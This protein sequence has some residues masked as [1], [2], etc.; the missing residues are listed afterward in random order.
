[1]SEKL[2][3]LQRRCSSCNTLQDYG[4][5]G[6]QKNSPDGLKYICKPCEAIKAQRYRE[7]NRST[8]LESQ[9]SYR[10][11][12]LDAKRARHK[13]WSEKNKSKLAALSATRRTK[14]PEKARAYVRSWMRE[15]PE[16]AAMYAMR[17][18]TGRTI[19]TPAW[20]NQSKIR[21]IYQ[22]SIALSSLHGVPFHVDHIVPLQGET[23]CGLHVENNLE[24]LASTDNI[25]K[26]NK[27]WPGMADG[28]A[29]V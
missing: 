19:A 8:Y 17:Y 27:V 5:F 20:A 15:N 4:V 2:E 14:D 6:K 25:K 9:N 12:N 7:R 24:I 18:R 26:S 21:A 29:N 11:R 16:K 3:V 1:M 28:G 13:H 10:L 22:L 23:V